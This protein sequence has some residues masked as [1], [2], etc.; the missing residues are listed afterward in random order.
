[1]MLALLEDELKKPRQALV[2]R[3]KAGP[4]DSESVRGW[5]GSV[6]ARWWSER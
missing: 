1:M 4:G 3:S 5:S 2:E 6:R